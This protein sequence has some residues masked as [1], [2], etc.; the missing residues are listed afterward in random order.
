MEQLL[1]RVGLPGY[2]QLAWYWAATW[3]L[4][5]LLYHWQ[6]GLQLLP[7]AAASLALSAVCGMQPLADNGSSSSSRTRHASLSAAGPSSSSS[8]SGYNSSRADDS[9]HSSWSIPVWPSQAAGGLLAADCCVLGLLACI[10][11]QTG[12]GSG[13]LLALLAATP[14]VLAV[15]L[16]LLWGQVVLS[17][18]CRGWW[19]HQELRH[20]SLLCRCWLVAAAGVMAFGSSSSSNGG[21]SAALAAAATWVQKAHMLLVEGPVFVLYLGLILQPFQG[22]SH[23]LGQQQQQQQR[24]EGSCAV[25]SAAAASCST[26]GSSAR[27]RKSSG[28]AA[29]SSQTA[30]A[31]ASTA[32]VASEPSNSSSNGGA[33]G[34]SALLCCLH[35]LLQLLVLLFVPPGPLAAAAWLPQALQ[36]MF[37]WGARVLLCGVSMQLVLMALNSSTDHQPPPAAGAAAL[38][39]SLEAPVPAPW[40]SSSSSHQGQYDTCRGRGNSCAAYGAASAPAMLTSD[41][42]QCGADSLGWFSNCGSPSPRGRQGWELQLH[43]STNSS[44]GGLSHAQYAVCSG[45]SDAAG[46]SWGLVAASSYHYGLNG[47]PVGALGSCFDAGSSS[48]SSA[49]AVGVYRLLWQHAAY[50]L[51]LFAAF[52]G[53]TLITA[54]VPAA[55]AGSMAAAGAASAGSAA[56]GWA[57]RCAWQRWLQ[58]CMVAG[59]CAEVVLAARR[60]VMLLLRLPLFPP[61][62]SS[63]SMHGPAGAGWHRAPVGAW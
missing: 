19:G 54:A 51:L 21:V 18:L 52:A 55:P 63:S 53:D 2:G 57:V 49:T 59:L 1:R 38:T 35:F 39:A 12:M 11:Q 9:S 26:A 14:Q 10:S 22:A 32:D 60:E 13:A 29:T 15:V 6:L 30:A 7:I 27:S 5:F 61:A 40:G 50:L 16:L 41:R 28:R 36:G 25:H 44:S 23:R 58:Y 33:G 42:H 34:A 31:A 24:P 46:C 17:V 62:G 43:S 48:G 8:R 20:A 45:G 47:S 37:V 56:A 4:G 3:V